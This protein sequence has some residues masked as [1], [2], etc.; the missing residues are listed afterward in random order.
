MCVGS[1]WMVKALMPLTGSH[2]P[3]TNW[4]PLGCYTLD[5]TSSTTDCPG[6]HGCSGLG[7]GEVLHD[8]IHALFRIM[9]KCCWECI[10][11]PRMHRHYWLILWIYWAVSSDINPEGYFIGQ[12]NASCVLSFFTA[13]LI[14]CIKERKH[15]L[16]GVLHP[17]FI[18]TGNTFTKP[19][20]HCFFSFL[21]ITKSKKPITH[22]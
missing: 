20:G 13:D 1:F 9:P 2:I 14:V 4:E 15:W 7:L 22:H 16:K 21:S 17:L 11:A 5:P 6:A 10:Q 19:E 18:F 8:I 12:C 3:H